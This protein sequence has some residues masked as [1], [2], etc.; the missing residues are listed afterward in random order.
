VSTPVGV[1]KSLQ[2]D[3]PRARSAEPVAPLG[4]AEA[5]AAFHLTDL[6]A[7]MLVFA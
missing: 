7:V 3:R 5:G 2:T 4:G 1:R 6:S